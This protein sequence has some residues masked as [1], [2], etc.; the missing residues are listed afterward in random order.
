[1][2]RWAALLGH[3]ITAEVSACLAEHVN[4]CNTHNAALAPE[5]RAVFERMLA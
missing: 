5:Q 2:I 3:D 4:A 1:M